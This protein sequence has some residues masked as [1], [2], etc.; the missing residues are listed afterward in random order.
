[1]R[2]LLGCCLLVAACGGNGGDSCASPAAIA[3][4][5]VTFSSTQPGGTPPPWAHT[6]TGAEA[7]LFVEISGSSFPT[8]VTYGGAPLQLAMTGSG[9]PELWYLSPAPPGTA[10]IEIVGLD[11]V[12]DAVA[13][14]YTGVHWPD[15]IDVTTS[16]CQTKAGAFT[17]DFPT[18]ADDGAA[19]V[20]GVMPNGYAYPNP[21]QMARSAYP[22]YLDQVPVAPASTVTVDFFAG[23]SAPQTVCATGVGIRPACP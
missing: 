7:A 14:S 1:M 19:I 11:T 21:G 18:T 2:R 13:A 6:V 9:A 4:D 8:S 20:I 17:F 23:Q 16:S 5:A 10:S 3:F 15:P 22:T 12:F